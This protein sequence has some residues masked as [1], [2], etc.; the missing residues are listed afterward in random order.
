MRRIQNT[1]HIDFT[2]K[3]TYTHRDHLEV[4]NGD[5]KNIN[6]MEWLYQLSC[7][8]YGIQGRNMWLCFSDS[9]FGDCSS[10]NPCVPWNYKI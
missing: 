3:R 2:L 7:W 1:D 10:V 6:N 5:T 4:E 9:Y 8:V